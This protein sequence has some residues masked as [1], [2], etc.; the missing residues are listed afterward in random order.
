MIGTL[1]SKSCM[2]VDTGLFLHIA[3]AL[4]PYFGK[5]LLDDEE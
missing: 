3:E 5:V 2:V 4:V 1:K